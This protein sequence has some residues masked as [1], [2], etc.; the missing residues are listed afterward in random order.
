MRIFATCRRLGI[1]TVAAVGPGD[2]SALHVR[3]AD[4]A[5]EVAS[6]L[7]AEALVSAARNAGATLV[8]PGYGFLAESAGFAE[9]VE[10]RG[11][12][13][14]RPAAGC[15][16]ARRRQARGEAHRRH[17]GRPDAA[18]RGA[19]GARLPAARQGGSGRRRPRHARRRASRGAR[20]RA[21][22]RRARGRGGVR[23]RHASSA[24]ATSP[25]PRH[26]EVQVLGDRHGTS[27]RSA[28]ATARCSGV[29]RRSSRSPPRP[30]CRRLGAR[31]TRRPCDRVRARELG[32]ESAGTG[33]VPRR[34]RARSSS[35]S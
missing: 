28:S 17:C 3:A 24:S 33:G 2:E 7:D 15:A 22:R 20:R 25:Q 30:A 29:T 12:H 26:V 23:R 34:R 19:G 9:A 13:V 21:R 35:W 18:D 4:E 6:Y 11:S 31:A 5:V 14:G 16:P 8:H 10:R 32:Y 1:G 27:S